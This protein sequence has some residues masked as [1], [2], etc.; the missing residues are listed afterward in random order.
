MLTTKHCNLSECGSKQKNICWAIH[1]NREN[2][3]MLEA[4]NKADDNSFLCLDCNNRWDLHGNGNNK[5]KCSV[6]SD[7]CKCLI[8]QEQLLTIFEIKDLHGT[9]CCL[10]GHPSLCHSEEMKVSVPKRMSHSDSVLTESDKSLESPYKKKFYQKKTQ[11]VS[12]KSNTTNSLK[13]YFKQWFSDD[14]NDFE[15]KPSSYWEK[16]KNNKKL[17]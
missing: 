9:A 12:V 7:N 3:E 1:Q 16:D 2:D 6:K 17:I 4:W 10:C 15:D 14:P 13:S 8:T 11:S 5:T